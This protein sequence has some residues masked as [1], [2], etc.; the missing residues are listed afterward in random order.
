GYSK[1][2]K[3]INSHFA[4]YPGLNTVYKK[5]VRNFKSFSTVYLHD[6]IKDER[7]NY[8]NYWVC[9]QIINIIKGKS[10]DIHYDVFPKILTVRNNMKNMIFLQINVIVMI[11]FL[12]L[13]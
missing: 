5:F 10:D 3:V 11:F 8:L 4:K 1:Y 6:D 9:D 7:C 12:M 2:S 13:R